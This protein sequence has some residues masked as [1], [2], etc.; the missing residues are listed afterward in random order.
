MGRHP[1]V[2]QDIPSWCSSRSELVSTAYNR[3]LTLSVAENVLQVADPEGYEGVKELLFS[4]KLDR[5]QLDFHSNFK[6]E[7]SNP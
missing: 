2:F 5:R 3:T 6:I 1:L 4:C 7:N